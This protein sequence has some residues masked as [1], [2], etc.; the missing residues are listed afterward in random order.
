MRDGVEARSM[1]AICVACGRS[2]KYTRRSP[3]RLDTRP[4]DE[5]VSGG[6]G[7]LEKG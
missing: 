3:M 6:K 7:A 5:I 4:G 2:Q 1:H